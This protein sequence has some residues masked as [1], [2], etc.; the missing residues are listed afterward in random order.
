MISMMR[1]ERTDSLTVK[2]GSS[3]FITGQEETNVIEFQQEEEHK[4]IEAK[5]FTS[6]K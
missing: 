5:S 4:P 3:T 2:L 1:T 6:L